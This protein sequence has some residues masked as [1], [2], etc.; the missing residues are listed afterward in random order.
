MGKL[1]ISKGNVTRVES[2]EMVELLMSISQPTM[3]FESVKLEV[4]DDFFWI[5][6]KEKGLLEAKCEI[7]TVNGEEKS[8]KE[9]DSVFESESVTRS[10]LGP[11]KTPTRKEI[12]TSEALNDVNLVKEKK[13][14]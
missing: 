5:R 3:L 13:N 7:R 11:E 6:V 2:Y 14:D 4:G 12:D 9:M 10:G 8:V 1:N